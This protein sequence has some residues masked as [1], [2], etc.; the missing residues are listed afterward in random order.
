[1]LTPAMLV[2]F[3]KKLEERGIETVDTAQANVLDLHGLP[4]TWTHYDLIVTASMLE[5]VPRSRFAE[6]LCGLRERLRDGG[7]IIL[8][9]TKRNWL[10]RPMI[11]CWWH[12]NLYD[13]DELLRA[14]REA[15]FTRITLL[16][17][18]LAARHLG[19]WGH[20]V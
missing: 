11:G 2:R 3:R 19:M 16:Q 4:A 14:F 8:F 18:P 10:T 5:Y 17:F 13:R 15:G 9:I 12:S 6:A 7:D 1:D 20:I